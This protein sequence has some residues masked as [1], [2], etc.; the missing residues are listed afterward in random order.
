MRF[1]IFILLTYIL[2]QGAD[3]LLGEQRDFFMDDVFYV[4]FIPGRSNMDATPIIIDYDDL[5][6]FMAKYPNHGLVPLQS[7]GTII[8]NKDGE[9]H[10]A[11]Y[12]IDRINND[13]SSAEVTYYIRNN[14][15]YSSYLI[16]NGKIRPLYKKTPKNKLVIAYAVIFVFLALSLTMMVVYFLE[17]RY[18]KYLKKMD[19]KFD[20]Y[21][22]GNRRV[23]F[24]IRG[25]LFFYIIPVV[26]FLYEIANT[27][28][29]LT[30]LVLVGVV[31]A[32]AVNLITAVLFPDKRIIKPLC[33]LVF[34]IMLFPDRIGI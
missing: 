16:E 22:T 19:N 6:R 17:P 2:F 1:V 29:N 31:M 28:R 25:L 9:Y 32:L 12:R 27:L 23:R 30:D 15:T 4:V 33:V 26:Y 18:K 10:R 8:D 14:K 13:Y 20:L 11:E 7:N 21:V 3:A 5:N 34:L 24:F